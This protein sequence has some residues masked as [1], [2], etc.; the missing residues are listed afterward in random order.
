MTVSDWVLPI[1]VAFY[2]Y[3]PVVAVVAILV[4]GPLLGFVIVAVVGAIRA[5]V[6]GREEDDQEATDELFSELEGLGAHP[7][8]RVTGV[9]ARNDSI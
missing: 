2:L 9:S 4:L 3:W 1:V 7:E 5:G 6:A 8:E